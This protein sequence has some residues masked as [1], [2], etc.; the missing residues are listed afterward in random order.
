[1]ETCYGK[2][3][4]KDLNKKSIISPII[5]CI[6]LSATVIYLFSNIGPLFNY[7]SLDLSYLIF[8]VVGYC[9]IRMVAKLARFFLKGLPSRYGYI[10]LN[11]FAVAFIAYMLLNILPST[12]NLF[13]YLSRL[14]QLNF[15]SV[16]PYLQV[17]ASL[18]YHAVVIVAGGTVVKLASP[19][20]EFEKWG[21]TVQ[22]ALTATGVLVAGYA[23]LDM[24]KPL[25]AL[26]MSIDR[27][28]VTLFIGLIAVMVGVIST[29]GQSS[30]NRLISDA[31][32]WLRMS[33]A[34]NFTLGVLFG[35]YMLF[36][37]PWV[38]AMFSYAPLI[39]WGVV[40][41]IVWMMYSG[42]KFR[43]KHFSGEF[44]VSPWIKHV[45]KVERKTG[46]DFVQL[47]II[48]KDFLE[49][50]YKSELLVYATKILHDNNVDFYKICQILGPLINYQDIKIPW[51]AFGWEKQRVIRRNKENRKRVLDNLIQFLKEG[52]RQ[53]DLYVSASV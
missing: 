36:V 47:N 34:R 4:G 9:L 23:M 51:F 14:S 33:Q 41:F 26:G 20:E 53:G 7:L 25:N 48:Q 16:L 22:P 8:P 18:K 32:N 5:P 42:V 40:C 15:Y 46:E 12:S 45:Q 38:I 17:L 35:I 50:G 29:Y 39:E 3:R 30:K 19:L 2:Y 6:V 28:G 31:C 24:L 11:G 21:K 43:I 37:R 44:Q 13:I 49:H 27:V 1:M 52:D 10:V